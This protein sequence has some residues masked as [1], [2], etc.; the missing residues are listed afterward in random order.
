MASMLSSFMTGAQTQ[1]LTRA[2]HF[3]VTDAV[4]AFLA[5]IVFFN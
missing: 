5:Y 3:G 1:S 2:F 4:F